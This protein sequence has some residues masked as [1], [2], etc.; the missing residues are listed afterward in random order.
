MSLGLLLH[1]H[2]SWW[3]RSPGPSWAPT[4]HRWEQALCAPAPHSQPGRRRW[5]WPRCYLRWEMLQKLRQENLG[6]SRKMGWTIM[7]TI[8]FQEKWEFNTMWIEASKY[9]FEHQRCG[10]YCKKWDV[11][12]VFIWFWPSNMWIWPGK[13]GSQMDGTKFVGFFF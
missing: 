12:D 3:P 1:P 9:G 7:W 11:T 13:I 8:N 4:E 2:F 5:R 6:L 10:F